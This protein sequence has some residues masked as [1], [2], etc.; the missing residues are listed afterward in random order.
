MSDI[1]ECELSTKLF[2]WTQRC[3]QPSKDL[4]LEL[5]PWSYFCE[6]YATSFDHFSFKHNHQFYYCGIEKSSIKDRLCSWAVCW[7]ALNLPCSSLCSDGNDDFYNFPLHR[8]CVFHYLWH[9]QKT[10]PEISWISGSHNNFKPFQVSW[11]PAQFQEAWDILKH[12]WTLPQPYTG[13]AQQP[14]YPWRAWGHWAVEISDSS[15]QDLTWGQC[16]L[17]AIPG[18]ILLP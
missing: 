3:L 17:S 12:S 10:A 5:F 8:L 7:P 18:P 4:A 1:S 15:I 11:L 9:A 14:T 2:H 6:L 13:G 16:L